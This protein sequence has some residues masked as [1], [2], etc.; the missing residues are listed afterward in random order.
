MQY[1]CSV[2]SRLSLHFTG[3]GTVQM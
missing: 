1:L 2:D 3:N